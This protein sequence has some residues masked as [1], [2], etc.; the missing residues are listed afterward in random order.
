MLV[1]IYPTKKILKS[2]VGE[3]LRYKETSIFRKEYKTDGTFPVV[4][5][6]AYKRKWY[7]QVTMKNNKIEKVT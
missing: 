1:A 5:P 7:A 6:D 2:S 4:G 3:T